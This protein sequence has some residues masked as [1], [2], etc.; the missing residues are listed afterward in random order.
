LPLGK[1][2]QHVGFAD[3]S[4]PADL[5]EAMPIAGFFQRS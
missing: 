4:F 2:A 5:D 1:M 3:A